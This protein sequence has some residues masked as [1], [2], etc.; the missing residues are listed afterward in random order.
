MYSPDISEMRST[1]ANTIKR[2]EL[3]ICKALIGHY[4]S[5]QKHNQWALREI[6]QKVEQLLKRKPP[7]PAKA[8]EVA[9]TKLKR[10]EDNMRN[11]LAD[12]RN[13]KLSR[14]TPHEDFLHS[15]THK[16]TRTHSP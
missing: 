13:K 8:Y 9:L 2:S 1:L 3:D 11:L 6:D 16:D 5:I 10:A 4:V 12:R 14:L 15:Y 7:Q